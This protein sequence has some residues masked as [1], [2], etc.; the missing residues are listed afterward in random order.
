MHTLKTWLAA[1]ATSTLIAGCA[2]TPEPEMSEA[3]ATQ[4]LAKLLTERNAA[5]QTLTDEQ[6]W[7]INADGNRTHIQS[8]GMC[9]LEWSQFTLNRPLIFNQNGLDVGCS[10]LSQSLQSS[11][12]FYFYK[13]PVP[14]GD[15]IEEVMAGIEARVPGG[16]PVSDI[17]TTPTGVAPPYQVGMIESTGSDGIQT[18]NGVFLTD[19]GGWRLKLRVTYP[20]AR[21]TEMEALAIYMLRGQMDQIS[22]HGAVTTPVAQPGDEDK[23]S[24]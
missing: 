14:V 5:A 21:A 10:Y 4:A 12:T 13:S 8:G 1:L 7:A 15:E 22:P 17:V 24:T 20:S 23:I 19:T 2:T 11:F 16:K 9:P 6:I 18:R 3:E